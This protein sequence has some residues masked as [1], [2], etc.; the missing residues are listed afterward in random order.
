[1]SRN[2]FSSITG[3]SSQQK[4]EFAFTSHKKLGC[5]LVEVRGKVQEFTT[6]K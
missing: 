2:E 3:I 5:V 6:I 1:M 4:L